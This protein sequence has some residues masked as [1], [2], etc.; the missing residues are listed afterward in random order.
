MAFALSRWYELHRRLK[1][2]RDGKEVE[3]EK[4][5]KKK[6]GEERERE[7]ESPRAVEEVAGFAY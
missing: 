4:K 1:L 6:R 5:K 2:V 3:E 7:R